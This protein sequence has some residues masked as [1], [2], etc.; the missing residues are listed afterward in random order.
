MN[1][2]APTPNPPAPLAL[3]AGLLLF[4]LGWAGGAQAEIYKFV[5]DNGLVTY[6]NMPRPGIKPEAVISEGGTAAGKSATS[7]AGVKRKASTRSGTPAYFPRVDMGTQRKRDDMRRQLL[8]EERASEQRNL[9]AA[10]AAMAQASRQPGA[11]RNKLLDAVRLHEKN[12]EMLNKELS[13]IR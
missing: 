1:A 7:A 10:K 11:D 13:H 5:D 6:T 2:R 9:A 12:I 3:A 4:C 8:E